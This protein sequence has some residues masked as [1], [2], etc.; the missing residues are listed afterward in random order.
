[1]SGA[2]DSGICLSIVGLIVP[3]STNVDSQIA[4]KI[5]DF[6]Y[7]LST[8]HG[9]PCYGD[10][11]SMLIKCFKRFIRGIRQM[12]GVSDSAC[13]SFVGLNVIFS[14]AVN[15]QLAYNIPDFGYTLSTV[16][17]MIY[18]DGRHTLPMKCFK[19]FLR[20]MRG[21]GGVS[22]SIYKPPIGLI[23]PF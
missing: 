6:G 8:K 20:C 2:S 18:C 19:S 23:I 1:M 11:H 5:P 10:D 14:T 15:S 16:N 21:V 22:E 12:G 7:P 13:Q 17:G 9:M 4:P 3:F